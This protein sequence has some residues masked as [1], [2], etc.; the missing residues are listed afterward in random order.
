MLQYSFNEGT[1]RCKLMAN[2]KKLKDDRS[3][4]TNIDIDIKKD[5]E[6][7]EQQ[8]S[9]DNEKTKLEE[10][11]SSLED[12]AQELRDVESALR[13]EMQDKSIQ[14]DETLK[15]ASQ[16][17]LD[18]A[19]NTSVQDH[20]LSTKNTIQDTMMEIKNTNT[21]QEA[22]EST[23]NLSTKVEIQKA[24]IIET[25]S[26]NYQGLIVGSLFLIIAIFGFISYDFFNKI[27]NLTLELNNTKALKSDLIHAQDQMQ[28]NVSLIESLKHEN[29]TLI[30]INNHLAQS[31]KELN[32]KIDNLTKIQEDNLKDSKAIIERLNKYEDRN[33]YA[34]K[35]SEAFFMIK[36][37]FEKTTIANDVKSSLWFLHQADSLL[38]NIQDKDILQLRRAIAEDIVTLSS[39]QE[40]DKTGIAYQIEANFKNIDNLIFKGFMISN[41]KEKVESLKTDNVD[42]WKQNLLTSLSD[43]SKSFIEIRR[44]DGGEL[45]EFLSPQQELFI[46]EN[47]KTR[48]TLALSNL[49]NLQG[50][51]F[52][53]NINAA[54]DIIETYFASDNAMTKSTLEALERLSGENIKAQVP[55]ALKSHTLFEKIYKN[56]AIQ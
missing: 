6:Q 25:K 33:P 9:Y 4:S 2:S 51:D 49:A 11:I 40:I 54:K 47:I 17:D 15:K 43:F 44:R 19:S 24:N 16:D 42:D 14:K 53:D 3:K 20:D 41:D 52:A 29:Q 46:R 28:E 27:N 21:S 12:K 37:A 35:I 5:I 7:K 45:T 39:V 26:K 30:S 31:N 1:I 38:I 18:K 22:L 13:Q 10:Q 50:K 55:D 23:K 36:Q 34:W 48:L 56:R 32:S 8:V